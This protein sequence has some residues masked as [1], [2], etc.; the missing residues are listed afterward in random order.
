MGLDY[1]WGMLGMVFEAWH[2]RTYLYSLF[3][4]FFGCGW[5]HRVG[6]MGVWKA[7]ITVS[8]VVK[9]GFHDSWFHALSLAP[10]FALI[11]LPCHYM[12]CSC[13]L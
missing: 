5:S 4:Y 2:I 12:L 6:R 10:S 1:F 9:R 11:C 7:N 8:Y 13:E 3:M